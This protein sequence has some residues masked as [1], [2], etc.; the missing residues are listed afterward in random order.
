VESVGVRM[1][2]RF[3]KGKR[4]FLTGHTGFKG[5]WMSLWLSRMGARVCGYALPPPTNPSLFVE[6]RVAA[7]IKS[8][9][10]DVRDLP[11][12]RRALCGFNPDIVIHM[13]AQPIVRR[14]YDE[15]VETYATNVLG[16]V[17]LL[18]AARASNSVRALINV[19]TDKVYENLERTRGYDESERLGGHDPYSNS[20]ACSEL[21]TAAYRQSFFSGGAACARPVA[22]ATARSGNVIGGGDWAQDRL[23]P[24]IVRA[25]S[26]KRSV[27][28]R[29]PE[30]VRPWQHVLEPLHGYLLLAE[31]L[32][33]GKPSA[34]GAWNFGPPARLSKPV[35]WL[36]RELSARWDDNPGWAL[37]KRGHVHEARQLS[38]N[39][40][41]A[42]RKLGWQS[43]LSIRETVDWIAAWYRGRLAGQSVLSLTEDQ[44]VRYEKLLRERGS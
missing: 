6:A 37:D 28:I 38:L 11:R 29:N 39:S 34:A 42:M 14:S 43:I 31:V 15:P 27:V 30:S 33:R 41:K 24:D 8:V 20:K 2:P 40:G 22:V 17:H 9:I 44:I 32:W 13:A 23:I 18:E 26:A 19:T 16:T 5:S 12:L 7:R 25:Y 21:V 1:D 4:V 36:V 35:S 3:W 10:G